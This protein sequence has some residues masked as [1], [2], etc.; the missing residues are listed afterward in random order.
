M[1]AKKQ[2][3]E[4]II[5]KPVDNLLD[6]EIFDTPLEVLLGRFTGEAAVARKR[7]V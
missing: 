4:E 3:P 7:S 1:A 2:T 6:H 5:A